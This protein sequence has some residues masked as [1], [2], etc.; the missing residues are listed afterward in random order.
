MSTKKDIP[1]HGI[2]GQ[3]DSVMAT[4]KSWFERALP[5]QASRLQALALWNRI[6][7][8]IKNNQEEFRSFDLVTQDGQR[9]KIALRLLSLPSGRVLAAFEDI[10][11][12]QKTTE[13]LRESKEA[14]RTVLDNVYD[15]IIIHDLNGHILEVNQKMLELYRINREQALQCTVSDISSPQRPLQKTPTLWQNVLAGHEQFFEWEARRPLDNSIFDIEVFLTRITLGKE[16]YVLANVRDITQRKQA[17]RSL[18]EREETFRALAEH[19]L[20]SIMRFDHQYRHLYVN[21]IAE[22]QSGIPFREFIGKTHQELGFPPDLVRIGEEALRKVF[23]T[24]KPNRIE[25]QLPKKIWIDWLLIPEFDEKG[26]VKAVMTSARDITDHKKADE[27]RTRLE[28]QLQQSQKMETIGRLAGGIAH[29]FNNILTGILGYAEMIKMS[30]APTDLIYSEA[31]EIR[32]ACRRAADLVNHLLAFSR[33]QVIK[34]KVLNLNDLISHSR[35]MLQRLIGEDIDFIFNPDNSLWN[36]KAD[37]GQC[38][39]VLI[40][41][42]INARD[43]MPQGGQLSIVTR[44]IN[45]EKSGT[46][47]PDSIPAGDFVMITVSDSGLGM[48]EETKKHIFEPFFSSK[49]FGQGTGLGL[50]TVYGIVQQNHGFIYFSSELNQGSTF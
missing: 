38:D 23:D 1:A 50:S 39:Q 32:K 40:N 7:D 42:V 18:R 22:L 49:E 29:D 46:M 19:S 44:N 9:R 5:D 8:Y 43:A 27:E 16:D 30:L 45:L 21:P 13:A 28:A 35:K 24:K 37:P 10:T 12:Q 25:F 20:D 34:P 3:S 4:I 31:D 48:T 26:E 15:A 17:E 47:G 6:T 33:K 14:L 36:I 2:N 41:L 11:E